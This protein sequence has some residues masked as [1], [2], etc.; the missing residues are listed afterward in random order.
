LLILMGKINELR[1]EIDSGGMIYIPSF[2]KTGLEIQKLLGGYT[3]SHTD[4]N[5]IS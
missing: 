2:L 5:V 1:L 4:S 3:C